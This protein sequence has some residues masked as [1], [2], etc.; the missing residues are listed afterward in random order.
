MD[1]FS[2]KLLG[3]AMSKRMTK[4]L[5][6]QALFRAVASPR[7]PAGLIQHTDRGGQYCAHFYQKLL[8][9]FGMQASMSRRRNCFDNEPIESFWGWLKNE[10]VHQRKH[11]RLDYLSPAALTRRLH[12]SK[13]AA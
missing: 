12:L 10:L 3:Y 2:E 11:E 6:M 8:K 13:I 5:T 1:L 4:H 9:Q 7:P